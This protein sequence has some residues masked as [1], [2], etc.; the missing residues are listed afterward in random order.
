[1]AQLS[2]KLRTR[3]ASNFANATWPA[4]TTL[5]HTELGDKWQDFKGAASSFASSLQS[6]A[7]DEASTQHRNR[8]YFSGI[9]PKIHTSAQPASTPKISR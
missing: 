6:E 4:S 8:V 3:A 7:S 9:S 2:C 5:M 1:L